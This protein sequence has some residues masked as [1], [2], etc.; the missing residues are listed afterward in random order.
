[1]EVKKLSVW[2]IEEQLS[3][4]VSKINKECGVFWA[5]DKKQ[6]EKERTPLEEGDKYVRVLG[7]GL[8]PSKNV[9]MLK[10]KFKEWDALK[11][12]LYKDNVTPEKEISYHLSN[13]ECYYTGDITPA[14][15]HFAGKYTEEQIYKVYKDTY[16]E[17]EE[18]N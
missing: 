8:M 9:P 6:Y 10:Q 4:E 2:E 11:E 12:K 18:C 5:F 14:I 13:F 7:G 3:Q 15:I 17:Y 16:H 1:M